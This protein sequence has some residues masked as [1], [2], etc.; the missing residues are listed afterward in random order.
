MQYTIDADDEFLRVKLW[1]RDQ[2]RPPSEVCAAVLSES[3]KLGRNRILIELD[4]KAALSP[5]SQV[6]LVNRLPQIG[7]TPAD[8]IALV[9][10]TGE[11]QQANQFIN[12]AAANRGVMVRNFPGVQDAKAWLREP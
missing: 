3:N 8:R 2:D 9:H 1:G 12:T 11:M 4:Q 7:F 6:M 5:A 10:R